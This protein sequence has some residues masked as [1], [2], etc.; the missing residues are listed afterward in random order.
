[1]NSVSGLTSVSNNLMLPPEV[2]DFRK[3]L[4]TISNPE[5]AEN[6]L[7]YAFDEYFVHD[8]IDRTQTHFGSVMTLPHSDAA[9]T[10]LVLSGTGENAET[11]MGLKR[12][13]V[14]TKNETEYSWDYDWVWDIETEEI[15]A[16]TSA[17]FKFDIAMD[18]GLE[19][20]RNGNIV[21]TDDYE[22]IQALAGANLEIKVI[23]QGLQYRNTNDDVWEDL[24]TQVFRIPN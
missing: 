8:V 2:Y 5:A 18:S 3:E 4:L 1:M 17:S 14:E 21:L 9:F 22:E 16:P 19:I 11:E 15:L 6:S 20:S 13:Y 12:Y 23:V 24:F 7:T 10:N